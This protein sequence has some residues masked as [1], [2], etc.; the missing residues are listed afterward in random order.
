M[1][2]KYIKTYEEFTLKG[3]GSSLLNLIKKIGNIFHIKDWKVY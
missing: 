3:F 1:K 2:K